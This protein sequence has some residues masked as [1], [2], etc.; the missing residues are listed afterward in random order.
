LDPEELAYKFPASSNAVD[1]IVNEENIQHQY[2][3]T[4]VSP[5]IDW[6]G[7]SDSSRI[8]MRDTTTSKDSYVPTDTDNVKYKLSWSNTISVG[9]NN[10]SLYPTTTPTDNF[11]VDI[12][13]PS[14]PSSIIAQMIKDGLSRH[15]SGYSNVI[16]DDD[17]ASVG[18]EEFDNWTHGPKI[19]ADTLEN[20]SYKGDLTFH[21]VYSTM[22]LQ[23]NLALNLLCIEPSF[24][25]NF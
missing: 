12:H 15:S 22:F 7:D 20:E 19:S 11:P 5:I 23:T 6:S 2:H 10:L 18:T 21:S 14:T 1:D 9:E 13:R 24:Y 8:D 4:R 25:A 3:L 16:D 17:S